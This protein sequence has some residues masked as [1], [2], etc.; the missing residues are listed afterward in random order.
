MTAFKKALEINPKLRDA[1]LGYSVSLANE[2]YSNE[3]L[4]QLERWLD[5]YMNVEAVPSTERTNGFYGAFIDPTKF[6]RVRFC[7]F[8]NFLFYLD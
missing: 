3:A 8:W 1:L 5:V 2:N 7:I 4:N 6:A